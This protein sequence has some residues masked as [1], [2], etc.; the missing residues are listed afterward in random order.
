MFSL[1]VLPLLLQ[2]TLTYGKWISVPNG[3]PWGE[4]GP[5][6]RC[7]PGTIARGY[8]LKVEREQG[9][10]DDTSVNAIRL[11]CIGE[12]D[13]SAE[14]VITSTEARWG[15]WTPVTWCPNGYPISFSLIVEKPQG[16]GDDTAVNNLLMECSDYTI[17]ES[18]GNPWGY[19]EGWSG[20]CPR[21]I[22]GIQAK[23]EKSQGD[24]DD[25]ALND[26]KFE[27]CSSSSKSDK[28]KTS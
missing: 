1:L 14:S 28:R 27:C 20:K 4:W 18:C 2:A 13:P 15:E 21:G 6:Q 12:S 8:S 23:V 11:H 10:G 24:G 9:S 5:I 17:L 16:D 7:P 26:V 22:C 19:G 25:T 3:G